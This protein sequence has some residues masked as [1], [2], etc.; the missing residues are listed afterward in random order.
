M[1]NI[2]QAIQLSK[3]R[4]SVF[5]V[6]ITGEEAAT[7][8]MD[9]MWD[10]VAALCKQEA[11]VAIKFTS[12]S[13]SC[14]FFS[15]IYPVVVVP[16]AYF[17]GNNGVPLEVIGGSVETDV[18]VQKVTA[19]LQKNKSGEASSAQPSQPSRTEAAASSS[20]GEQPKSTSTEAGV[21]AAQED[22]VADAKPSENDI[23]DK[24]ER[25]KEL[26]EKKKEKKAQEEFEKERQAEIERRK[27]GQ[28]V[29]KLKQFQ[30]DRE[31]QEVREQLKK[32]KEE[33]RKARERIKAEIERDRAER[34]ARFQKEKQ[35]KE[36]KQEEARKAKLLQQQQAAQEAEA[37]RSEFA[38]IQFRL[39]DGSSVSQQFA[40]K[41]PLQV[42][43]DFISQHLGISVTLS[44]AYPRRTFS[45]SQMLNS[46]MDLQLAPSAAIIVVPESGTLGGSGG[47][48][49]GSGIMGLVSFLFSPLLM[50]WKFILSFFSARPAVT[51]GNSNRS[52]GSSPSYDGVSRAA[53]GDRMAPSA[54]KR[55]R[56]DGNIRRLNNPNDDD[57][58]NATWNGN[59]TQQM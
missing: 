24:V 21:I 9:G 28:S 4:G 14:T 56:Q 2:P 3:S 51:Q 34:N 40:S 49:V 45:Q 54:A 18:F 7:K 5:I 22:A 32:E 1:G 37:R 11:A 30:E 6:Y 8:T 20:V 48:S 16:S 44:T 25:A 50:V 33:E 58:E 35:E 36:E 15:Q 19:V 59:S 13:E 57:D 27:M 47:P 55:S 26:I 31:V 41:E 53:G 10:K 52:A 46:F 42:A 29:Q 38:R 39:P 43:Y 23:K 12:S 17:I